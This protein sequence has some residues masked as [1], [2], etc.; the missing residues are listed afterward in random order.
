MVTE[1]G[2]HLE[3]EVSHDSERCEDSYLKVELLAHHHLS[4]K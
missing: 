3:F 2:K 1:A 4:I